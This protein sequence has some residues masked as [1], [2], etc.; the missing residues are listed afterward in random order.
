M[1]KFNINCKG[2]FCG[3]RFKGLGDARAAT[4]PLVSAVKQAWA[5]EC[6]AAL[7]NLGRVKALLTASEKTPKVREAISA[8]ERACPKSKLV[9]IRSEIV[10]ELASKESLIPSTWAKSNAILM[11]GRLR[12]PGKRRVWDK[13]RRM[14]IW[15]EPSKAE[16]KKYRALKQ[17]ADL[18]D[19]YE[20][21]HKHPA[22][23]SRAMKEKIRPKVRRG[24]E[25]VKRGRGRPRKAR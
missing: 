25:T 4:Q 24:G 14:Y 1:S 9:G 7:E 11:Q 12:V 19:T 10:E 16:M 2:K 5:G 21:R 13:K 15:R 18:I 23:G 8:I 6:G 17:R 3:R 20:L 22:H